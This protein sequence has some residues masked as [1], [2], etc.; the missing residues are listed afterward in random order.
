MSSEDKYN[1]L[2]SI[3]SKIISQCSNPYGPSE[4]NNTYLLIMSKL[5]DDNKKD[6]IIDILIKSGRKTYD[7][8]N[9]LKH[10][11]NNYDLFV[12]ISKTLGLFIDINIFRKCSYKLFKYILKHHQDIENN[13][14]FDRSVLGIILL[15]PD[16]R[17]AKKII[18]KFQIFKYDIN[19]T[20]KITSYDYD[21]VKS[22]I[23]KFN[24]TDAIKR[25]KI[26]MNVDYYYG[27]YKDLEKY[28]KNNF[29]GEIAL[30]ILHYH[31]KKYLKHYF[32]NDIADYIMKFY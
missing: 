7:I 9:I 5:I 20:H 31:P 13:I 11:I 25:I 32:C 2:V 3:L 15:N 30:F 18:N 4:Y 12:E 26:L 8:S 27:S 14:K 24:Y 1:Y 17:L 23:N 16:I 21:L 6:I 29:N 22:I 10:T 19:T 28:I